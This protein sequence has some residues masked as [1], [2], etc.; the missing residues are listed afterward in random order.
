MG[1]V[2]AQLSPNEYRELMCFANLSEFFK[3]KPTFQEYFYFYEI[4][5]F[6]LYAQF[7]IKIKLF[8]KPSQG[9]WMKV[10]NIGD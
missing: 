9:D 2:P 10:Q 4:R 5:R 3:L 8:S 1:F 7:R 6:R